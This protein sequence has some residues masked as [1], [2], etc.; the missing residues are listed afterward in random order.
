M[1]GAKEHHQSNHHVDHHGDHHEHHAEVD[2]SLKGTPLDFTHKHP[3]FD[4]KLDKKGPEFSEIDDR[5][6]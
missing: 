1:G 6:V 2:P 5:R 3:V 4:I